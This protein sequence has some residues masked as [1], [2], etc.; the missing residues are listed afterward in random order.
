M[1][2]IFGFTNILIPGWHITHTHNEVIFLRNPIDIYILY[3]NLNGNCYI[4]PLN[5]LMFALHFLFSPFSQV[6]H[7]IEHTSVATLHIG[8]AN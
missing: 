5:L 3:D 1:F 4:L 7:P 2:S 8:N 6:F